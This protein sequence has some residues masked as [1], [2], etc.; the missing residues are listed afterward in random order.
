MPVQTTY[1][2]TMAAG[3]PGMQANQEPAVITSKLVEDSSLAFGI[4]V[5][6]GARDQGVT[7]TVGTVFEGITLKDSTV[8][9]S[10]AYADRY[11]QYDAAA[12]MKKGV[13]FVTTSTSCVAGEPVFVTAAGLFTDVASGDTA[14][15]DVTFETSG[16]AGSVVKL[17]MA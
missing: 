9:P 11:A 1:Q 15:A 2:A 4:A 6:K 10:S 5:F 16:S 12:V 13:I 3:F 8:R 17:R 7:A 14:L